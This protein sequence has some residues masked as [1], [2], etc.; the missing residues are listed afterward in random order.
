MH[1]ATA[2]KGSTWASILAQAPGLKFSQ[3]PK[4]LYEQVMK[5][6]AVANW[7]DVPSE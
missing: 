3:D 5:M 7:I 4:P 1:T 6:A 2:S